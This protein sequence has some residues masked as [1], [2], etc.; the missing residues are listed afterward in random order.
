MTIFLRLILLHGVSDGPP[1][2]QSLCLY[3][4][5]SQWLI[6]VVFLS[7][8]W[9]RFH[10]WA[11][12][13]SCKWIHYSYG[14]WRC[15]EII[16]ALQC[17]QRLF[18]VMT[19]WWLTIPCMC[20]ARWDNF[21]TFVGVLRHFTRRAAIKGE[22]KPSGFSSASK[23]RDLHAEKVLGKHQK[24]QRNSAEN[25]QQLPSAHVSMATKGFLQYSMFFSEKGK[26]GNLL[27]IFWG[28]NTDSAAGAWRA[29]M[30]H[31]LTWEGSCES[32]R[33]QAFPG[34][35]AANTAAVKSLTLPKLPPLH[36]SWWH[37]EQRALQAQGGFHWHSV[38]SQEALL[39]TETGK[40]CPCCAQSRV[41][42]GRNEL[43]ATDNGLLLHSLHLHSSPAH[44]TPATAKSVW[45]NF[46][47]VALWDNASDVL[48]KL[49]QAA[50]ITGLSCTN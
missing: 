21:C 50:A 10:S 11:D 1:W 41:H 43:C 2:A 14:C 33:Q 9:L 15:R 40:S 8:P 47:S 44:V 6:F 27:L 45:I 4:N 34:R 30:R 24:P 18:V 29:N 13:Q 39:L 7:A 26:V 37:G 25:N 38:A 35:Q 49:R 28:N 23:S 16:F 31:Q 46:S 5:S 20:W 22:W 36:R 48:I 32:Y 17:Y 12:A 42:L 19:D 3:E